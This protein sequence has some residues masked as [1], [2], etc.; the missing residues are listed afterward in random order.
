MTV[1]EKVNTINNTIL[2]ILSNVILHKILTW[3]DKDLPW[4]NKKIKGKIHEKKTIY[5]RPIAIIVATSIWK[6]V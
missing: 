3:D 1:D 6:I 5:L 4:L 2:I